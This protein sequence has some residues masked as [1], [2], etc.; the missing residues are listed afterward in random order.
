MTASDVNGQPEQDRLN[1]ALAEL[2]SAIISPSTSFD[3]MYQLVLE[4]ARLLTDSQH[5]F[6]SSID[7]VTCAHVSNTLTKMRGEGCSV[8]A[9][10]YA[11]PNEPHKMYSGLWGYSLNTQVSFY[12]NSPPTHQAAK[13]LPDGHLPLKNFLSVPVM[14]GGAILGQ[15]A[16]AN[17]TRDYT[18]N[19]LKVIGRLSEL[20]A[21]VLHNRQR[22]S[23]LRRSEEG[24]RLIVESAPFPMVVIKVSDSTVLYTNPRAI[25][26]FGV[27]GEDAIGEEA[28]DRYIQSEQRLTIMGEILECGRILDKEVKMRDVKGREFWALLS[29][30]KIDWFGSEAIMATINDITNRKHMEE[31]LKHLATVDYLTGLWN[32][33]HFMELGNQEYERF[34]RHRSPLSILIFDLDYFKEVN[35]TYGHL[36]GDTVLI[37]TA[38][39]VLAEIRSTDIAGRYGG[40]ELAV[41]LPD[42]SGRE[43]LKIAEKLRQRIACRRY[44]AEN[45]GEMSITASFGVCE[46]GVHDRTFEEI[47]HRADNALYKAKSM[48]R[49]QLCSC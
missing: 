38:E 14:F 28:V 12:T 49:N 42:T 33:R 24:F 43:A 25:E 18:D 44:I 4:N 31:S 8:N 27:Y 21:V 23:E 37:G 17:S 46:A 36:M 16:L 39:I 5:G 35:D 9:A 26:L 13:G 19:D 40:E 3:E 6:V 32:R 47:I 45:S 2:S 22:E 41:I 48:G 7:Q 10:L 29:A 30:V 20:Y 15:I 11:L 1:T 34:L